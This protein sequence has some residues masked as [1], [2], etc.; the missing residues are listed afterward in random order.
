MYSYS[1]YSYLFKCFKQPEHVTRLQHDCV[2]IYIFKMKH[3]STVG[4]TVERPLRD[5]ASVSAILVAVFVPYSRAAVRDCPVR[6][7]VRFVFSTNKS[8]QKPQSSSYTFCTLIL[9]SPNNDLTVSICNTRQS[10]TTTHNTQGACRV[11]DTLKTT[12][13]DAPHK[14]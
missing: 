8:I 9:S 3:W 13:Q 6:R 10:P 11:H 1:G 7:F 4:Y 14:R 12:E 5:L 2:S